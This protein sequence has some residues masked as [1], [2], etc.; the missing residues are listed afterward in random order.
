MPSWEF[1]QRH[2]RGIIALRGDWLTLSNVRPPQIT[3]SD[4]DPVVRRVAFD[5]TALGRWDSV[6]VAFLWEIKRAAVASGV[7]LDETGLPPSARALL[8]LLPAQ[9][10]AP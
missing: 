10:G 3:R 4:G 7:L 5:T 1:R 8:N 9:P 2:N 6:L